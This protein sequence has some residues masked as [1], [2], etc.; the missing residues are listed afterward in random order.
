MTARGLKPTPD[1]HYV[2]WLSQ[3]EGGQVYRLGELAAHPD[4]VATLDLLLPDAIPGQGWDYAEVTAESTATP[5]RPGPRRTIVGR[6]QP[7]SPVNLYP[8][9]MPNTGLGGTSAPDVSHAHL[10]V[11]QVR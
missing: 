3:Q 5:E 7:Y 2:L 8:R 1:V 6:F 10:D 9:A 4:G 11:S